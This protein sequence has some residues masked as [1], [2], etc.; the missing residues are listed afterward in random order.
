MKHIATLLALLMTLSTQLS[1]ENEN[2]LQPKKSFN[3]QTRTHRPLPK[4][5]SKE[6]RFS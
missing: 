4:T 2:G 6:H 5:P 1:A 3:T